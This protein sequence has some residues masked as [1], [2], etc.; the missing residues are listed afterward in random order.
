MQPK[1]QQVSPVKKT[2]NELVQRVTS[3]QQQKEKQQLLTAT[4]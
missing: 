1:T 2:G 3:S 4:S